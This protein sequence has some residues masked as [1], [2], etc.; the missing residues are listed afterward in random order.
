MNKEIKFKEEDAFGSLTLETISK[1]DKFNYW[2]YQTIK[3]FC[4]GKVLEIGSG[5]G[6]ISGFFVK[7]NYDILLSDIRASYCLKLK[8]KFKKSKNILGIESINLT[9]P[10]FDKVYE[11]H[12][13]KYDTVFALNVVEHIKNDLLALEN[14]NKLLTENG[15]AIILVP[16]YQKL[17]NYYDIELGH[18]R[19]YNKKSLSNIFNKTNFEIIHKQYFNFIGLFGWY[20][21]GSILKKKTIPKGQM[22]LYN[23]SVP[24]IKII[25]KIIFCAMGLS[26]I[27]VA[28][29]INKIPD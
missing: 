7:D 10:D 24:I 17:F 5:I 12:L 16:S 26:T 11:I 29:K 2:M 28:K 8:E 13:K 15:Y 18:Y 20:I 1:A 4:K 14:C 21:N 3:P 9:H 25:D 19:R 27:I 23:T 6:N 22:Q